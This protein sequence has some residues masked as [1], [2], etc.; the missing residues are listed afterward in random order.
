MSKGHLLSQQQNLSM[1]YLPVAKSC[2]PDTSTATA[3]VPD[4]RGSPTS[5][6]VR[7][8]RSNIG[9]ISDSQ[10]TRSK[11]KIMTSKAT[12]KHTQSHA[13]ASNENEANGKQQNLNLNMIIVHLCC[14]HRKVCYMFG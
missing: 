6:F 9:D 7:H 11:L 1:K 14:W 5:V 10:A 12:E 13:T 8:L 4:P 2:A 3:S